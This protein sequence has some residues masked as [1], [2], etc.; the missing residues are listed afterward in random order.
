[1]E[2]EE[3]EQHGNQFNLKDKVASSLALEDQIAQGA[4]SMWLIERANNSRS[5]KQVNLV[6][7]RGRSPFPAWSA[8]PFSSQLHTQ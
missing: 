3:Q 1:M 7:Y 4:E 5:P 2:L 6:Q 8:N